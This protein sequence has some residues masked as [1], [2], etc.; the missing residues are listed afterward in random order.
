MYYLKI[1]TAG[2]LLRT[3]SP[4][5]AAQALKDWFQEET[6]GYEVTCHDEGGASVTRGQ[7]RKAAQH[8][9]TT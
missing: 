9:P 8:S 4:V 6:T 7:L 2:K 1:S 3:G 5:A